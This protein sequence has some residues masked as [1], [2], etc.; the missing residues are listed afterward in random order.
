MEIAV[1]AWLDELTAEHAFNNGRKKNTYGKAN[2]N[3]NVRLSADVTV[4]FP[5][6]TRLTLPA[7]TEVTLYRRYTTVGSDTIAAIFL[8][9]RHVAIKPGGTPRYKH[10][11]SAVFVA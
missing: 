1:K 3:K 7:S 2:N 4:I 8:P 9:D 10:L 11:P 6:N 5:D